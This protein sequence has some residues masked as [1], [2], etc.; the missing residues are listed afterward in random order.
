[1]TGEVETVAVYILKIKS[2]GQH[3]WEL[4]IHS[5]KHDGVRTS[6]K[7][8]LSCIASSQVKSSQTAQRVRNVNF[9]SRQHIQ[10]RGEAAT[11]SRTHGCGKRR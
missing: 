3:R 8:T 2:V 4:P 11:V 10:R 7:P 5:L 9:A 1:M 6:T